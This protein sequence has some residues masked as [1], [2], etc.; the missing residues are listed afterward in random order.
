[1][2]VSENGARNGVT[3]CP[4]SRNEVSVEKGMKAL[5]RSTAS[6]LKDQIFIIILI[7]IFTATKPAITFENSSSNPSN[8]CFKASG[9]LRSHPGTFIRV[10]IIFLSAEL[11]QIRISSLAP[12]ASVS[13]ALRHQDNGDDT[14]R[15]HST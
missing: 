5:G 10:Q 4:E 3:D 12:V 2:N 13:T 1:M 14:V 9:T 7:L 8:L 11:L 15:M 6:G